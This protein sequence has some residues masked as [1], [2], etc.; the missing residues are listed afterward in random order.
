MKRPQPTTGA[1]PTMISKFPYPTLLGCP[2]RTKSDHCL[3]DGFANSILLLPTTF[4]CVITPPP[5]CDRTDLPNPLRS[6]PRRL[7]PAVSGFILSMTINTAKSTESRLHSVFQALNPHRA[8]VRPVAASSTR[9]TPTSS[10]P[11]RHQ[12]LPLLGRLARPPRLRGKINPRSAGSSGSSRTR[13]S[14]RRRNERRK[15]NNVSKRNKCVSFQDAHRVD[16]LLTIDCARQEM[17]RR[18]LERRQLLMQQQQAARQQNWGASGP[19]GRYG[20]SSGVRYAA[21]PMAYGRRRAG[22]GMGMGLPILGVSNLLLRPPL[23]LS[24]IRCA[25]RDWQ[26]D[27]SSETCWTAGSAMTTEAAAIG[28]E[29]EE[30]LAAEATLVAVETSKPHSGVARLA[31]YCMDCGK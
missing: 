13:R 9:D 14:V 23:A 29:A 28:E 24:E 30:T 4:T 16:L 12:L 26:E 3:K 27:C 19:L 22:G 17:Q 2:W 25:C 11:P 31:L 8:R 20:Y 7:H 21:P 6:T 18:Y 5:N 15:G 10:L 1:T